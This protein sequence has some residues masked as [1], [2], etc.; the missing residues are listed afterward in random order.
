MLLA[1]DDRGVQHAAAILG[2]DPAFDPNGAG[3]HVHHHLADMRGVGERQRRRII[4]TVRF[5]P[6]LHAFRQAQ[7]IHVG[8]AGDVEQSEA[9]VLP[10]A[11]D[12]PLHAAF[13]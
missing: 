1:G 3:F 2:D 8:D 6:R 13:P 11:L 7:R 9:S 5:E 10:V 12:H 4:G